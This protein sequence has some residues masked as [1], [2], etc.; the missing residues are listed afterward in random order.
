M[1]SGNGRVKTKSEVLELIYSEITSP[2]AKYYFDQLIDGHQH[3]INVCERFSQ[4]LKFQRDIEDHIKL[5][6][7]GKEE[8][9]QMF[10]QH[11]LVNLNRLRQD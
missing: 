4:E 1:M 10:L 2:E 6:V 9:N 11:K 8:L 5:W 7:E 3:L